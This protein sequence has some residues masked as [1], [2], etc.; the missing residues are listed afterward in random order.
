MRYSLFSLAFVSAALAAP[1]QAPF[2]STP[3]ASFREPWALALLPDERVLVT[4]KWLRLSL[5]DPS[6]NTVGR[7]TGV[8]TNIQYY[9]QGGLGDVVLHPNY[10]ENSLVYISYAEGA[11]WRDLSAAAVARAKLVLDDNGGGA[12]EDLEVIWRQELA[13]GE[14]GHYSHRILF[15]GDNSTLWISSGDR[16]MFDPAQDLSLTYGKIIRLNDDGTIP[17]GNPFN[18]SGAAQQVWA[19]GVRNSLGMDWDAEGRLWEIEMGP[20]GGDE[21][22]LITKGN[23]YGWPLVSNG[24]HYDGAPIPDHSTR[25]EFAAPKVSWT[26]VISPAGMIIYKGDL[27]PW[28]GSAIISGLGSQGLVRVAID[29]EDAEEVERFPMGQGMRAIREGKDGAIWVLEDGDPG[30]LLKLTPS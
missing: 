6:T 29:G 2:V 30:R 23:N 1:R 4:E 22:N 7:I 27:F 17:E 19:L 28:K 25:P 11:L 16:Q 18:G 13:G 21:L 12:L 15:G 8:P 14:L 3:I 5:V 10:A 26:P 24:D 9:D 20:M